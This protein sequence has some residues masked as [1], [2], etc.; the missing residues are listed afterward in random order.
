MKRKV[1]VVIL[2]LMI[3]LSFGACG[4]QQEGATGADPNENGNEVV[5]EN[6]SGD[7]SAMES[8]PE[9][10]RVMTVGT[11]NP[12]LDVKA[13]G[14]STLVQYQD[15]YFLVDCGFN[16]MATLINNGVKISEIE[17]ML[18]THQHND[19]NADFWTFF[20]GGWGDPNGRRYLNLIGPGT[21]DL[22]DMTTEFYKT[23]IEYR[24]NVGFP[25]EGTLENVD[26]T[27]LTESDFE[28]EIDGVKITAI[29][30]PHTIDTY[31]YRFEADGK[32][33][34]ISGDLTY[35]EDFAPFAEDA[36]LLVMDGMMT[37][38][39]SDVPEDFRDQLI[40]SLSKSHILNEEIGQIAKESNA[41]HLVLTHLGGE[42]TDAL[43]D[44]NT[45]VYREQ[46]FE[47]DVTFGYDGMVIEP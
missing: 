29:P 17:Q 3:T 28:T 38:D 31:A 36:D 1:L 18:F 7:V 11:G 30:V 10:F 27:D 26:V 13:G 19:H 24:Q 16:S 46:G 8:I 39:Y 45:E 25:P 12:Q 47:G 37:S 2:V 42:V 21:Q 9:G 44:A 6:D 4:D 15:T 32:S 34:V 23:D 33:V 14:G 41:E 20:I 35:T 22:Y 5:S 40:G 43:V